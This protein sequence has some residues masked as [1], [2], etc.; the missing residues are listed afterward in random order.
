MPVDNST[1][2]PMV[3][4][5]FCSWDLE[6]IPVIVRPE[7]VCWKSANIE[8][9]EPNTFEDYPKCLWLEAFKV[10]IKALK[11]LYR[12]RNINFSRLNLSLLQKIVVFLKIISETQKDFGEPYIKCSYRNFA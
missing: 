5:Y 4:K 8:S 12:H 10:A 9:D 6:G 2:S 3:L 11:C 7:K 1:S